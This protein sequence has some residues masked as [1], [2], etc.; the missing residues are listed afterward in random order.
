MKKFRL[1]RKTKKKL[2]G[3]IW[4]YPADEKGNSLM[5]WPTRLQ[6]DYDAVKKGIVRDI[7]A[8]ST[9]ATRKKEKAI[10]DKAIEVSDGQLKIFVDKIFAKEYRN[11]SY[12]TLIKA[13]NSSKAV[14]AYYNFI[15]A[16]NLAEKGEGSYSNICCMS[17][18]L[19]R[20]LLKRKE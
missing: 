16:Y 5:A 20:D 3:T 11:S 10:L 15:N 4:L 19:A 14:V 1:P 2:K 6:K 13:K 7:M 9:K 12:H 17:V 8:G 18:D